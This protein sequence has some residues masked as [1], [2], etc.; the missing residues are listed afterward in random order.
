[1]SG[2]MLEAYKYSISQPGAV[3]A[4]INYYRCM[5][6][7]NRRSIGTSEMIKTPILL[8][9]VMWNPHWH[10]QSVLVTT[11]SYYRVIVLLR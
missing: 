1:M 8:I 9:W 11:I 6:N 3:T 10:G 7:Q 5:L 2:E 4:V